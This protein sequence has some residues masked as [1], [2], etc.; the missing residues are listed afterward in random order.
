MI[1]VFKTMLIG[2]FLGDF[3]FQSDQ[4]ATKKLN[5][6]IALLTHAMIYSLVLFTVSFIFY[7]QTF[8]FYFL[9]LCLSHLV[10]DYFKIVIHKKEWIPHIY[11]YLLDQ[12][13]HI[14]LLFLYC[15]YINTFNAFHFRSWISII[16]NSNLQNIEIYISWL[17]LLIVV[18]QPASITIKTLLNGFQPT[19]TTSKEN[20]EQSKNGIPKA[21]AFIGILERILIIL[22]LSIKEYSSIGLGITAKSVVRYK[23][24][25]EDPVFSEYYLLGTL[26]STIIA[27]ITYLLI[28]PS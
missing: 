20:S 17:L 16:T 19:D 1:L 6:N 10:V 27:V 25:S 14:I 26:L 21:G 13:M 4:L 5:D 11:L 24:I 12:A 7:T 9:L 28:I 2:H 23:K 15:Y 3:Y 8:S 22:M 18:I